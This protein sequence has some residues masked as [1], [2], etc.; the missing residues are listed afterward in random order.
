MNGQNLKYGGGVKDAEKM[1]ISASILPLVG[2]LVAIL[3]SIVCS[4][5]V[6]SGYFS[7]KFYGPFSF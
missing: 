6:L 7:G 1:Q 3:K 2:S 4:Y 5:M